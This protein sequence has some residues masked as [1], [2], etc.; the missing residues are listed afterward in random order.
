MHV[1]AY[2]LLPAPPA[3]DS[4]RELIRRLAAE[5]DALTFEPH[6]TLAIGPDEP[7]AGDRTLARCTS[8]VIEVR[9]LGVAFSATFTR[10]LFVRFEPNPS[11]Q[12]LRDSLGGEE[13]EPF[14]PHVS[15]LYQKLS[16]LRRA[17]LAEEIQLPFVTVTFD[18]VAATRCRI[19]VVA[20]A[21]V[22]RWETIAVRQL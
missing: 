16:P 18:S 5:N 11:L 3:R 10:T 4:F 2:W 14:D 7:G 19:P 15:L 6:L 8:G 17:E 1:M 22:G 21:D 12:Q 9:A 20:A 13:R